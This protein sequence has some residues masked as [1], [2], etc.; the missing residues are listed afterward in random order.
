M[1]HEELNNKA[2]GIL[3]VVQDVAIVQQCVVFPHSIAFLHV[4]ICMC[5]KY[6]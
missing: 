4:C 3:A 5:I 1:E 2:A 6:I